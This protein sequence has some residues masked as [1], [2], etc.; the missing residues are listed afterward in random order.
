VGYDGLDEGDGRFVASLARVIKGR[1]HTPQVYRDDNERNARPEPADTHEFEFAE[2]GKGLFS[3]IYGTATDV[4]LGFQ[5]LREA[6]AFLESWQPGSS[7]GEGCAPVDDAMTAVLAHLYA[8]LAAV[9][10]VTVGLHQ[11]DALRNVPPE[12]DANNVVVPIGELDE[13][14][15]TGESRCAAGRP[16]VR[17]N[18]TA[19]PPLPTWPRREAIKDVKNELLCI[20]GLS[21]DASAKR[22]QLDFKGLTAV[23]ASDE[24][25]AAG[26]PTEPLWRTRVA[27][28]KTVVQAMAFLLLKAIVITAI[29]SAEL[30]ALW[31]GVYQ[32]DGAAETYARAVCAITGTIGIGAFVASVVLFVQ[33]TGTRGFPAALRGLSLVLT[34]IMPLAFWITYFELGGDVESASGYAVAASI[35]FGLSI[36]LLL[37]GFHIVSTVHAMPVNEASRRAHVALQA[38]TVYSGIAPAPELAP[39]KPR[40]KRRVATAMTMLP[41]FLVLGVCCVY[42]FGLFAAYRKAETTLM[43]TLVYVMAIAIKILGNK[44]QLWVMKQ[45]PHLATATAD[46]GAFFYE[47]LAALMCRVLV[48]SIPDLATAQLLSVANS[49]VEVA[50]RNHFFVKYQAAGQ[51]LCTDDARKAW[52]ERGFWRV[53]DSN[54]DNVIEYVT[55]VTSALI[56]YLLP[57]LGTFQL[58]TDAESASDAQRL[59]QLVAI[60]VVPEVLID[61]WCIFTETEGGLGSVHLHYWRSMSPLT[62]LAKGGMCIGI[63][64]TVLVACLEAPSHASLVRLA[65][66]ATQS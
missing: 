41:V 48:L 37:T 20:S 63:I 56:L 52:R 60:N 55:T 39:A 64:A 33:V 59:L 9:H 6:S 36:H 2:R 54:N 18:A 5:K 7:T 57:E 25:E 15:V 31:W 62:V 40:K 3:P 13:K 44:A 22:R 16:D 35:A 38:F 65:V 49:V 51:G 14:L 66:N 26:K 10:E 28:L 46:Q 61:S 29:A 43:K 19:V 11:L 45:M 24:H 1:V 30:Y 8:Q 58:P 4:V 53:L 47:F 23:S 42:V 50:V 12:E 21:I 34:A 17:A 27:K 32:G